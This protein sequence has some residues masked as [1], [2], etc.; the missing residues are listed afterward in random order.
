M[1]FA[2]TGNA[3]A[4]LRARRQHGHALAIVQAIHQAQGL[5]F[6]LIQATF[7]VCLRLHAGG[8]IKDQHRFAR[9]AAADGRAHQSGR[10]QKRQQ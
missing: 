2:A 5:L 9:H 1:R 10:Q 6:R 4:H 3:L 7:T 8:Q